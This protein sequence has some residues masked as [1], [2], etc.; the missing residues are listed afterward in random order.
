MPSNLQPY[1]EK[2]QNGETVQ[3]RPVGNSMVPKIFSKQLVT[4]SPDVSSIEI[5]DVLV[6]KVNGNILVHLVSAIQGERIQISNNKGYVNGW[7]NKNKIYG[8]V[9][10]IED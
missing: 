5:G 9:I 3:F 4:V 8:K 1:I 10:K 6:C 7:T 2:L